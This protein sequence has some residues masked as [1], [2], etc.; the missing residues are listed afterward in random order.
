MIKREISE[1]VLE[2]SRKFPVVTITGPRQSGKTTL[3][4]MLFPEKAYV[5]LENIDNREFALNDPKGFLQKFSSGAVIDEIQR[6]PELL[7]YI[8]EIVDFTDEKGFYILTGS[9]QFELLSSITQSLAGRTAVIKLLPFC[10]NEIYKNQN[11]SIEEVLY[12]GFYPRIFKEKINPTDMLS[13]YVNTYVERDLRLLLNIKNLS[14]FEAF[15]KL[16][17]ART[18]QILNM[19]SVSNEL[20][21]DLKT[22]KSWLSILEASFIIKLLNPYYK[23]INKRL[24]KTPKLYF[25]DTGLAAFLLGIKNSEQLENH[26]LKGELFETYVI[27]ELWKNTYNKVEQENLYFFRNHQG[28]EVDVIFDNVMSISQLEIKLTHTVKSKI[29]SSLSYLTKAGYAVDDSYLVYG[30]D[31]NYRREG[32]NIKSWRNIN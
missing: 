31:D 12:T 4:R 19:S 11:P 30:G 15:L 24:I 22:V 23:N 3:C 20:G 5:S 32:V 14:I 2:L 7:S 8:Q 9:Q 28:N 18:G 26:P 6:V 21:I 25:L 29:L 1:R 17:A 13:F 16:C 27:G 10:Y